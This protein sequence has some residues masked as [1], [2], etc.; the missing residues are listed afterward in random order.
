MGPLTH[1][2]A[3]LKAG[4]ERAA[5][6]DRLAILADNAGDVAEAAAAR[7]EA[8]LSAP[9]L[10]RLLS[11]VDAGRRAG[12]EERTLSAMARGR[13]LE[14]AVRAIM[15]VLTGRIDQAAGTKPSR[16]RQGLTGRFG[17][18][19]QIA[20]PALLVAGSDATHSG[21]I[22]GTILEDLVRSA[23]DA[24]WSPLSRS[25]LAWE[26]DD[27]LPGP[28]HALELGE[29]VLD[30]LDRLELTGRKRSQLLAEGRQI[31]D[32]YIADIVGSKIRQAYTRA[33]DLAVAQAEA[34]AI[35]DGAVAGQKIVDGAAARYP[36]HVA[37]RRELAAAHRRSPLF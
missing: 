33:A 35:R 18:W 8:W 36:R 23:E 22:R 21:R 3:S 5:L 32:G 27:A 37:F 4:W 29:L 28:S 16:R 2:V 10:G 13:N 26:A 25:S 31:V 15:Q 34:V 30:A 9:S 14:P 19:E 6:A 20:G 11:A 17:T 24:L 1:G 7:A 12:T